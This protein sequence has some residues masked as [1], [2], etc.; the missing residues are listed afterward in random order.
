MA[1]PFEIAFDGAL[2]RGEAD[3]FGLP[4]VFLHAECADRRMW[5][6]Q[7]E[8][9]AAEGYHVMSYDRRG[10]GATESEDAPFNAL[11][12]LETVLDQLSLHAVVLVGCGE[13]GALALDF[14]LDHP[15]RTVGLILVGTTV[16][17]EDP[18]EFPDEAID[19]EDAL[20]YAAARGHMDTVNRIEAHLYLDGPLSE[21]GRVSG[22]VR[23]LFL[24]MNG[25]AL[26]HA[27]LTD[28]E[29]RDPA[30]TSLGAVS[31]PT[32]LVVGELDFPDTVA[33][34]ENLSEEL[35]TAFAVV[36]EDCARLAPLEDPD[37]FNPLLLEY[38]EAISGQADD[39]DEAEA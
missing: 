37:L 24:D 9:L 28:E 17:G 29:E 14:A 39:E 5:G 8:L 35:E 26:N 4:V 18:P 13:G 1:A 31:A 36:L 11:I 21:S 6:A 16:T 33:L 34:H 30:W 2:I 32:L 25:I 3:G 12:D 20:D 27:D 15:E 23:D 10:F 7:M 22:E 38:L 19:L